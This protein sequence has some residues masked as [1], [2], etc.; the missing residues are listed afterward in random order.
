MTFL[1]QTREKNHGQ[2]VDDEHDIAYTTP[3][4]ATQLSRLEEA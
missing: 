3:R 4:H 2:K 1:G